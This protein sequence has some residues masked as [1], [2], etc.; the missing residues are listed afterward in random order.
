MVRSVIQRSDMIAIFWA[1]IRPSIA[2]YGEN[3][4]DQHH[5]RAKQNGKTIYHD[6]IC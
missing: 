5:C 4:D 1:R 6:E 2:H 3:N